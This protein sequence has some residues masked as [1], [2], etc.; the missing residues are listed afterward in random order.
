MA[1]EKGKSGNPDGRP[2]ADR[3]VHPKSVSGSA[4]R[5]QEFKQIIRRMKPLTKKAIT[6]LEKLID[7]DGTTESTRMRAIAFVIKEYELLINEVYKPETG[8][9]SED[10]DREKE[11]RKPATIVSF[12]VLK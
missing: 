5:E 10:D 8:A 6:R 3:L 9:G 2:T 4:I 11:E 1:F 7:D 12:K